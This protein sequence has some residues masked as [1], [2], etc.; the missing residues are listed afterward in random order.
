MTASVRLAA[1]SFPMMEATWNFTV[2]SEMPRREAISLFEY[3]SAWLGLTLT[4][5]R[6]N[7][8][9]NLTAEA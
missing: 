5:G 3:P 4:E 2:W 8:V 9:R 7:Q 1:P 6:G